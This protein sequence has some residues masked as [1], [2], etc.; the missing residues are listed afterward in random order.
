MRFRILLALCLFIGYIHHSENLKILKKL[1][2]LFHPTKPPTTT[3]LVSQ[4]YK[5]SGHD[6]HECDFTTSLP[7]SG[8][9]VSGSSGSY[10]N[11]PRNEHEG[12]NSQNVQPQQPYQNNTIQEPKYSDDGSGSID[13]RG[14]TTYNNSDVNNTIAQQNRPRPDSN[15]KDTFETNI[16]KTN[17]DISLYESTTVPHNGVVEPQTPPTNRN[18]DKTLDN[19]YSQQQPPGQVQG[20]FDEGGP[21]VFPTESETVTPT[22]EQQYQND[23]RKIQ[24]KYVSTTARTGKAHVPVP[25]EGGR[26]VIDTPEKDC[27]PG[28]R[29]DDRG[30]CRESA[31]F[32]NSNTFHI[33]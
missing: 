17:K 13:I 26:R 10:N 8:G 12:A 33:H 16:E 23:L 21:I 22:R 32:V 24:E 9:G 1:H 31:R 14:A 11:I 29:L 19:T 5:G 27:G 25:G 18:K 2:D 7:L 3:T 20:T 30:I 28:R 4:T 15:N 6:L